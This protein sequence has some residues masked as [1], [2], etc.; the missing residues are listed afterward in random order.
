M[1]SKVNIFLDFC[2]S[3]LLLVVP[4]EAHLFIRSV[5]AIPRPLDANGL[6]PFAGPKLEE[7]RTLTLEP[8]ESPALAVGASSPKSERRSWDAT[9]SRTSSQ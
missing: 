1:R 6:P 8:E 3:I 2:D 7:A 9:Y 4:S 5:K